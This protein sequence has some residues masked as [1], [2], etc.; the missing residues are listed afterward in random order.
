M[1]YAC[2]ELWM[3]LSKPLC[4]SSMH[5]AQCIVKRKIFSSINCFSGKTE[6]HKVKWVYNRT[7]WIDLNNCMFSN[8]LSEICILIDFTFIRFYFYFNFNFYLVPF[9]IWYCISEYSI[10]ELISVQ[11]MLWDHLMDPIPIWECFFN[12]VFLLEF[13]MCLKQQEQ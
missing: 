1:H 13:D 6:V 8:S 10:V 12:I 7:Q 2:H 5:T 4:T 11:F 9:G 3:G